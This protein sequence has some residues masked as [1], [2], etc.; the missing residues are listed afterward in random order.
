[1]FIHRKPVRKSQGNVYRIFQG[2]KFFRIY[3]S[4]IVAASSSRSERLYPETIMQIGS[5]NGARQEIWTSEP[6]KQ[7][8]SI[9]LRAILRSLKQQTVPI[10]PDFRS[11]TLL[12]ASSTLFRMILNKFNG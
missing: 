3:L 2:Y 7:P 12:L 8:I 4:M 1:M 6:G 11:A 9:S 5:P 10:S